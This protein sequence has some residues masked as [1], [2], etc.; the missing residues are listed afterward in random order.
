MPKHIR[1]LRQVAA[2][3]RD[4]DAS[5]KLWSGAFGLEECFRDDLSGFGLV[6]VLLPVGDQFIELLA[7]EQPHSAGARFL[8]RHGEAL[9]MTIF[10]GSDAAA[11]E[12]DLEANQL[13]VAWRST[14]E[15]YTSVHL[16][17]KAMSR[18]LVSVE[19]PTTPGSWP[20]A[21]HDWQRHVRTELISG[22]AGVGFI[23]DSADA[24]AGRW[25]RLFGIA[26]ERYWLQDGLR[27]ANAPV[28][29][30]GGFVEFQQPVDPAAPASRYLEK[31]GP[32]MY[33]LAL[34]TPDLTKVLERATAHGVQ[35]IREDSSA[36]GR[37]AWLHPRTMHGVLT[38]IIERR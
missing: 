18:V 5:L 35:V 29:E 6:N 31:H 9:Y 3:T 4:L 12:Q 24:D 30:T 14:N 33:Y 7:P 2:M 25:H 26:P 19:H 16:H 11:L 21:G 22:I 10:E 15:E 36:A 34:T 13:P 1:R 37:S 23:T 28:G 27:I 38:E 8:E 32:G 20:A 17:P